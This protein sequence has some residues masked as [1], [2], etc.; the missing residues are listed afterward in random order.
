MEL[1]AGIFAAGGIHFHTS[2]Q[3]LCEFA[4]DVIERKGLEILLREAVAWTRSSEGVGASALIAML[5]FLDPVVALALS[6]L[7]YVFWYI[8]TP[9]LISPGLS[10]LISALSSSPVQGVFFIIGLSWLGQQ[11]NLAAVGT[12][13]TG[14]VLYRWEII[15]RLIN[16]V[17]KPRRQIVLPRQDRIL[18]ALLIRHAVSLG[19]TLPILESFEDRIR[20]IWLRGKHR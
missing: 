3:L 19:I 13:L 9:L 12:G 18:R 7:I 17:F 8:Y 6:L 15:A 10:R 1:P 5:L 11:G 14:F 4:G 16:M 2:E 20:E